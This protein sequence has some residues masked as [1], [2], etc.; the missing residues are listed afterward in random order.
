MKKCVLV[1][2]LTDLCNLDCHYCYARR[3]RKSMPM[4]TARRAVDFFVEHMKGAPYANLIFIGGEPLTVPKMIRSVMA[5]A[6]AKG[7]A[8]FG[9][10]TNGHLLDRAWLDFMAKNRFFLHLSLDGVAGAQDSNRPQRGGAGSFAKTDRALDL[11]GGYAGSL[12]HLELRHTFTPETAHLIADSV[13]YYA[14]KP[15]SRASRLCLM[16]AMLPTGRWRAALA[17]G[18]L[19]RV[20]REQMLEVARQALESRRAGAPLQLHY[21]ECLTQAPS[22]LETAGLGAYSCHPGREHLTV[23][24]DGELYP[25]HIPSCDPASFSNARYRMGDV[26]RGITATRAAGEFCGFGPN[27]CHS[28]PQ[29][30]RLETGEAARPAPVYQA[31]YAAWLSAVRAIGREGRSA[32]AAR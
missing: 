13:A 32:G 6:R 11:L 4:A 16:P 27:A 22:L 10:V 14:G 25:C 5:Y 21:N 30:N 3:G 8:S 12:Q 18:R 20:L 29:W 17:Q 1:L 26:W 19:A 9:A 31:L 2:H 28:C 7:L 23:N 24:M 15:F